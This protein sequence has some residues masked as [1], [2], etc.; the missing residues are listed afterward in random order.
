LD[1]SQRLAAISPEN[2]KRLE[3]LLAER[4]RRQNR[5]LAEKLKNDFG[6]FIRASWAIVDPAMPLIDNWHIDALAEHLQA[7]AER[8]IR[9]L[10]INIGPGYAK[11]VIGS[12]MFSAWLWTRDAREK[13]LAATYAKSLTIR[14]SLRVKDLISSEWYQDVFNPGWRVERKQKPGRERVL[15][16]DTGGWTWVKTNEDWLSNSLKGE[17]RALTVRGAATGFRA[18]GQIF[19][20]LLNASERNSKAIRDDAT[21]WAIKTMSSRFNDMRSGWRVVIGQRLHEQDPYG[22]M[23]A[24]GDYVHL[25]LPSE[26]ERERK[27]CM[28]CR[29]HGPTTAIGFTDPR[30]EEGQLLF[31]ELFTP[32]VIAQAKKDLG[33]YDYAGQ[34]QQRPAPAEGGMFKRRYWR[35]YTRGELPALTIV[36]ISVDC[37]FKAVSDSD[38]VAIHVWGVAGAS[39]YLLDRQHERMGFSATKQAIRILWDR[40]KPSATLI[41][42]KANGPAVIEE[43]S[44]EIPGVIAINPEGGKVARAWA[45]Q[46]TVEAGGVFLPSEPQYKA[47][48]VEDEAAEFPNGANDDDV[49]AM[50]QFLNWARTNHDFTAWARLGGA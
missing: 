48:E 45:A 32:A 7:V 3:A 12:V 33:S 44:R 24:T 21:E 6:A 49:D 14:D 25:N 43:L 4:R 34:H 19:D 20:D 38:Y 42:D 22:A 41:E 18:D 46:P 39:F 28:W 31:P 50:T 11:S 40:W 37:T 29:E 15:D 13:I 36:V 5:E 30:T 2:R 35:W 26:F 16:A 23:L 27:C 17:R 8:E 1:L 47:N 10:M 9:F